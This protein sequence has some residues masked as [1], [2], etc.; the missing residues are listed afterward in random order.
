MQR[1]ISAVWKLEDVRTL[2]ENS[3]DIRVCR[4]RQALGERSEVVDRKLNLLVGELK[5]YGVSVAGVHQESKW[6]G[7]EVWPAAESYTFLHSGIRECGSTLY[8]GMAHPATPTNTIIVST[9]KSS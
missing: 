4:K 1:M 7:K 2:V 5:M 8:I 6:F 3:G 9:G